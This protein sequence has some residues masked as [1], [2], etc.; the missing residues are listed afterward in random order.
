MNR[1]WFV[2][3]LL[4]LF[5]AFSTSAFAVDVK[6]GAEYYVG[7]LYLDKTDVVN[8]TDDVSTAF[9]Y[10]RLRVGT[11]F[12]VSPCL[13]LVTRFDA[14]ERIWGGSRYWTFDGGY[15]PGP[16]GRVSVTGDNF[17]TD[18]SAG[19]RAENE[20]IAFDVAYIDYVSPIGLFQ[21]GYMPDYTWGLPFGN[22]GNGPTAGQIKWTAPIKNTGFTVGF[23]YVKEVDRSYNYADPMMWGTDADYDS[24]RLFGIYKFATGKVTG[25]AGVLYL[26]ERNAND[27][28]GPSYYIKY[29]NALQPYFKAKVGIVDLQGEFHYI[30]GDV[31][32]EGEV[33]SMY[34]NIELEQIDAFLDAS[35]NFGMVSVGGTFAYLSGD[36][37]GTS[38]KKEGGFAHAGFDWQPTL[39]LFNTET[40]GYWAGP[41]WGFADAQVA[42]PMSN[43]WFFQGRVGVKPTP[44]FDALLSI[45]YATA[46]KKPRTPGGREYGS[47]EYGWEVD[48]TGTYKI[49]NNLSYMLGVGYLFTGDYF[50]GG[51]SDVQLDDDFIIL[52]KLTLN[53]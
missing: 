23:G 19:S 41:I 36:K 44:A 28:G 21:V 9:F 25:E 49:T 53:F 7:G 43:A 18:M 11:D 15:V 26:Y 39:L 20:N 48:L 38:D 47:K 1:F 31:K 13:K 34:P 8:D 5:M 10:Q 30:W 12:I 29:V 14:M 45:S 50:K 37:P 27:K 24:Y 4:G 16:W 17:A 51:D 33:S 6:V 2:L 52:N 42:T 22:R 40:V 32:M 46:D 3:L 35:A